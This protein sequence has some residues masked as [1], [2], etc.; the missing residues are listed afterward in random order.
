[1]ILNA[2]KKAVNFIPTTERLYPVDISGCRMDSGLLR[3]FSCVVENTYKKNALPIFRQPMEGAGKS[4]EACAPDG[5]S[6]SEVTRIYDA[7]I[8]RV[9]ISGWTSVIGE[10]ISIRIKGVSAPNDLLSPNYGQQIKFVSMN[11]IGGSISGFW[12]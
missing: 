2:I 11:R 9:N 6:L 5:T 1:M 8:F 7:D 3:N 4:S 10:R 12:R